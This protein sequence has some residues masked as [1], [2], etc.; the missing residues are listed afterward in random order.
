MLGQPLMDWVI[1]YVYV[2]LLA[3]PTS[4]WNVS[5]VGFVHMYLQASRTVPGTK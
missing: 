5:F 3:S 2:L 4:Y 1:C